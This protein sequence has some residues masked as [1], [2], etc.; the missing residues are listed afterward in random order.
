MNNRRGDYGAAAREHEARAVRRKNGRDA[1]AP[2]PSVWTKVHAEARQRAI[3]GRSAFH[4]VHPAAAATANADTAPAHGI[5]LRA[6]PTGSRG[7]P[8]SGYTPDDDAVEDDARL[9][10]IS[11]PSLRFP[12]RHVRAG[13]ESAWGSPPEHL[14]NS[15]GMR[16][17]SASVRDTFGASNRRVPV[18]IPEDHAVGPD[19]RPLI[20]GKALG[21]FRAHV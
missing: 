12:V 7:S 21:L 19:V 17:T 6:E 3:V 8:S 18:N 11:G 15:I 1:R 14:V 2:V 10:D 9:A 5:H 20:H 16:N 13:Y 4:W